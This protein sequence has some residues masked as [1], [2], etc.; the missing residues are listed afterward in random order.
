MFKKLQQSQSTP[1]SL[2][3]NGK[4]Q[5]QCMHIQVTAAYNNRQSSKQLFNVPFV[6]LKLLLLIRVATD[7]RLC[8]WLVGRGWP[9]RC[10]LCPWDYPNPRF[11]AQN[12]E[13]FLST[14]QYLWDFAG[15]MVV[16]LIAYQF[17]YTLDILFPSDSPRPSGTGLLRERVRCVNLAQ[18]ISNRI[19]GS[20]RVR[21]LFT[22]TFGTSSLFWRRSLIDNLSSFVIGMFINKLWRNNDVTLMTLHCVS[23]RDGLLHLLSSSFGTLENICTKFTHI[24]QKWFYF[25]KH[26]TFYLHISLGRRTWLRCRGGGG[27][28]WPT[29]YF[30]LVWPWPSTSWSPKLTVSLSCTCPVEHLR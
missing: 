26:Y 30:G 8:W 15:P 14:F 24:S 20:L 22:N 16:F 18:K 28:L 5:Q 4:T 11:V 9:N 21:K 19:D 6:N 27:F 17:S 3:H 25:S 10:T 29:L 23:F 13:I 7:Q 2:Y 1:T 12:C